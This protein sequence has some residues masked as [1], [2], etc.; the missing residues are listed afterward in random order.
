MITEQAIQRNVLH[1]SLDSVTLLEI[2]VWRVE[3]A[4][5]RL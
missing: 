3:I 5:F 4:P 2:C 1:W